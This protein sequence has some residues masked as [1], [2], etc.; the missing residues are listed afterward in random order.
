MENDLNDIKYESRLRPAKN[1]PAALRILWGA[2]LGIGASGLC[3]LIP[4][5]RLPGILLTF[6][7]LLAGFIAFGI[8]NIA[9]LSGFGAAYFA[10]DCFT[11]GALP[12][13][14][15][16]LAV[17]PILGLYAYMN[18][19]LHIG[20]FRRMYLCLASELVCLVAVLGLLTLI[21]GK[22]AAELFTGA[23][24]NSLDSLS[25][26]S[27]ELVAGY[28]RTLYSMFDSRL[29]DKSASEVF[30]YA[31]GQMSELIK[32][33]LPAMLLVFASLNVLP[34][35]GICAVIRIKKGAEGEEAPPIGQWR[36]P[37]SFIGG[38]AVILIT[39]FLIQ[40]VSPAQGQVV[41]YTA[42]TAAVI[43]GIIQYTASWWDRLQRMGMPRGM[44]I[45]FFAID[46]IFFFQLIPIYG[47]LSM[48]IGSRGIIRSFVAK[49]GQNRDE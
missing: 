23:L 19:K 1:P 40:Y 13:L 17:L 44:R 18:L 29:A 16:A 41:V 24:E 6:L 38:L 47:W 20:F 14:L 4:I 15:L 8:G 42:L 2:L 10:S 22:N 12:A 49:R 9:G 21:S 26:E 36:L 3:M 5:V 35:A 46:T 7:P 45:A 34:G 30:D 28:Y 11:L 48:L 31:V 25:G 37:V 27:R 43:M 32:L 39:A 33:S